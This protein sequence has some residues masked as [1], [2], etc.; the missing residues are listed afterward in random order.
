MYQSLTNSLYGQTSTAN[1]SIT[2]DGLNSLTT[3][4]NVDASLA[5]TVGDV[6]TATSSTSATWQT[7]A[8]GPALTTN[9]LESATTTVNVSGATA[10]SVNQVLT[11][12]SGTEATWQAIPV[13]AVATIANGLASATTSVSVSSATAP[14]AGQVLTATNSTTATWV[15]PSWSAIGATGTFVNNTGGGMAIDAT[16][17]GDRLLFYVLDPSGN[18]TNGVAI[19]SSGTTWQNITGITVWGSTIGHFA[20]IS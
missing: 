20:R 7:P 11:A 6:L 1:T 12:T 13:P 8:S 17:T 4:V 9:A 16:T 19:A 2:A 18:K 3:V 14:S 5:P 10:P 15:T